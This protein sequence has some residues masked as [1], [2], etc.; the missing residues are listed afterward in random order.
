MYGWCY[1]EKLIALRDREPDRSEEASLAEP[2]PPSE[3]QVES[4]LDALLWAVNKFG[5]LSS[6]TQKL[7]EAAEK[8][9]EASCAL[10]P[11]VDNQHMSLTKMSDAIVALAAHI[12]V[13]SDSI[14]PLIQQVKNIG[15]SMADASWQVS[16]SGKLQNASLKERVTP[17]GK[18]IGETSVAA[19]KCIDNLAQLC[20]GFE[21]AEPRLY[22]RNLPRL[23]TR[24]DY[25]G[26]ARATRICARLARL[27]ARL[28]RLNE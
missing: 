9:S 19:N 18:L 20:E 21:G 6:V 8:V 11:K 1:F 17:Q 28:A 24:V 23:Y 15:K 2:G 16:G 14:S 5:A 22:T 27:C 3:V 25:L 12:K 4:L 7:A 13:G 26:C 10:G